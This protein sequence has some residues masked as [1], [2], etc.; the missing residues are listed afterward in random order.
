MSQRR[1]PC[2]VTGLWPPATGAMSPTIRPP[3]PTAG[4]LDR[5]HAQLLGPVRSLRQVAPDFERQLTRG[6]RWRP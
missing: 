1:N 4:D 5:P 3:A 2:H 6:E